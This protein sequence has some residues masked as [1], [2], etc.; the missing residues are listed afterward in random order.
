MD[1]GLGQGPG[2]WGYV[3]SAGNTVQVSVKKFQSWV[4]GKEV[5]YFYFAKHPEGRA[6]FHPPPESGQ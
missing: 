2:S 1:L 3:T 6:K 5:Y 4:Q